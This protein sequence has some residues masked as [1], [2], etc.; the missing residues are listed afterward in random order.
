MRECNRQNK[1]TRALLLKHAEALFLAHGFEGVSIRQITEA[2]DANVA[3]VNYHFNGKTNLYREV[4]AQRLEG[5][6]LEKLVRE[7]L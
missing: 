7:N 6:T 4:L 3:A 5:I 2:S 1:D